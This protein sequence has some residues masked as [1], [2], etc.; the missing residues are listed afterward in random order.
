MLKD[1][2]T[3]LYSMSLHKV[4]FKIMI[5]ATLPLA[6]MFIFYL[7]S[8]FQES[9]AL[10]R[11]TST[12]ANQSLRSLYEQHLRTRSNDLVNQLEL[13]F[14]MMENEL[15][16]VT[17]TAQHIIDTPELQELGRFLREAKHPYFYDQLNFDPKLQYS[18]NQKNNSNTSVHTTPRQVNHTENQFYIDLYS[19]MK[20]IMP[21]A[22]QYGS[23]KGWL[24]LAGPDK[25][26]IQM[27]SPWLNA[28]QSTVDQFSD[29]SITSYHND[30]ME[31]ILDG[32][33]EWINNKKTQ[34]LAP[35]G[36]TS[37]Q[38]TTWSSLY[39]DAGGLGRMITLYRP[40]WS[41][42]RDKIEGSIGMDFLLEHIVDWLK[43]DDI[44]N[45]GF[46]FLVQSDSSVLGVPPGQF[47]FLGLKEDIQAL[48]VA[49]DKVYLSQSWLHPIKEVA[50][51]LSLLPQFTMTT[52]NGEN[53]KE[54]ILSFRRV[55]SFNFLDSKIHRIRPEFWTIGILVATDELGALQQDLSNTIKVSF[56]ESLSF[57]L[58]ASAI[59]FIITLF[60]TGIFSY[61]AT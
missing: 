60:L 47:H 34:P 36:K 57:T 24:G 1:A 20:L 29:L 52:F 46:S 25:A 7:S 41:K 2:T 43:Q 23:K 8:Q 42:S 44:E 50:K 39:Q 59:L 61:R 16:I 10:T 48:K 6:L 5:M 49:Y 30:M 28:V 13:K 18:I 11:D 58:L 19:P 40:L 31:G 14:Q 33:N 12:I 26:T 15:A 55:R 27:W 17:R 56:G 3:S 22:Q 21:I 45:N 4:T 9:K 53:D 37:V 54:Y 32:W 38:E 51:D 35:F